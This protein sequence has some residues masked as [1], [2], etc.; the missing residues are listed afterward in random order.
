[1]IPALLFEHRKYRHSVPPPQVIVPRKPRDDLRGG[2]S[3]LKEPGLA[4]RSAK[5]VGR[6]PGLGFDV[7]EIGFERHYGFSSFDLSTAGQ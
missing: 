4:R 3:R 6:F 2:G 5:T 1:V 7:V